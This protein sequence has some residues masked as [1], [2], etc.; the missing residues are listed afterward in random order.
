MTSGPVMMRID[1]D[2]LHFQ[3]GPIDLIVHAEGPVEAVEAAYAQ[4]WKRF[5]TILEEL[6][7]ELP[8]LRQP[9][10]EVP[11][12]FAGAVAANMLWST[13]PFRD[14]YITPMAAVAGCVAEEVLSAMVLSIPITRGMVNNGGDI[15]IYLAEFEKV[16]VGVVERPDFPEMAGTITIDWMDPSRGIATSGWRGR[17]QSLGIAD[18][19]TIIAR[20][21]GMADAAATMIANAV[22]IDHPAIMRAPASTV[23]DDTDLGDLP[24]TIDVSDLP[25]DAISAAL[26]NGE[27]E[28][29]RLQ[30][31]GLIDGAVLLLQGE[32]RV[33]GEHASR[34]LIEV[35]KWY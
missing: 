34:A 2:R 28:A 31:S 9:L 12:N 32:H 1:H 26:D 21:A 15:A 7:A 35:R 24:V 18:A 33:I 13:W 23:A 20:K 19:A 16:T 17:S 29:R 4:A 3:H 10:T 14:K 30:D 6:V 25:P 5:G 27:A 22:N 11:V 8:L